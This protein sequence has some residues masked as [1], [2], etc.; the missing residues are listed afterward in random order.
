MCQPQKGIYF[1]LRVF[2]FVFDFLDSI[3]VD[4]IVKRVKVNL[5][6]RIDLTPEDISSE[7]AL[8]FGL[9]EFVQY[10]L[11]ANSGKKAKKVK[12]VVWDLDNTLWDGT[13]VEDGEKPGTERR[14]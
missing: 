6:Y 3:L 7:T 10:K 4:E 1:I 11:P 13:L 5:Q 14:N 8:Y 9:T 12:C 2:H